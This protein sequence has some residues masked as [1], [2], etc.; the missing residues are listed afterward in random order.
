LACQKKLEDEMDER[1]D[2]QMRSEDMGDAEE[3]ALPA[4]HSDGTGS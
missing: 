1:E 2:A 3:D 4:K